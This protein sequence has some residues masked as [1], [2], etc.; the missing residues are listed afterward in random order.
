MTYPAHLLPPSAREIADVVGLEGLVALVEWRGGT[1]IFVPVECG[2]GCELAEVMGMDGAQALV[3]TYAGSRLTLPL[4]HGHQTALKWAAAR[5]MAA[6]GKSR[7][8][9]ARALGTTERNVYRMLAG[10]DED[11]FQMDLLL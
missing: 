4:L 11:S 7:W 3:D 9:I 10:A 8:Q 5:A 2:A 6:D 1:T